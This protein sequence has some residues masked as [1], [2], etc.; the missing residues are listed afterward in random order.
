MLKPPWK[1]DALKVRVAF[2]EALEG[3]FS[4]NGRDYPWR[5]TREPYEILISEVML[6][7]TQIATVLGRGFYTRFLEVFPDV[8]S[9]AVAEDERLLKAWEGLGY[10]RRVR[11]LRETARAVI[12]EHGGEFPQELEKLMKLPG[13]GRYTAGALRGFA[14]D[15]PSAV[16]DGNVSRV[17]SRVM[18]FSD[19]VDSPAGMKQM[20]EWAEILADPEHPRIYNSALMEL[21]QRICRPGVPDCLSCPVAEFCKTREPETLPV[22]KQKTTVTAVDE[23]ALWLRDRKGRVLL[24]REGGKR[25]EGLWKLPTR[26]A[27]EISSLP[28]LDVSTYTITRYRVTLRAHDGAKL[29]KDFP[30]GPDE[31]WVEAEN[32]MS[33]AMPSPFRRVIGRLLEES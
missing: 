19:E 16:V 21:G 8:H 7:Q 29:A 17:L 22:K 1:K 14:F 5:R 27:G 3:W 24:H 25:R 31:V 33:L 10:Y 12:T 15:L 32:V 30:P 18:D 26:E 20:W 11:M 2:R 23:H 6:Q 13:V 28:V 4:E 9:L